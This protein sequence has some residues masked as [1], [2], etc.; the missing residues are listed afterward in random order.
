MKKAKINLLSSRDEYI[1]IERSLQI[2]RAVVIVYCSFFIVAALSFIFLQYQQNKSIQD[3]ID[4]KTSFL[5]YL[6]SYKE[7]E[8]QLV[9]VAKKVKSYNE[10]IRDDARFLPYYS[11]LNSALKSGQESSVGTSSATLS[12]FAID[13]DRI[14]T[15][16]LLFISVEDMVNSFKYVESP[17]FL[18]NFEQLSLK[19]LTVGTQ[20]NENSLSF[21]G[22]FKKIQYETPN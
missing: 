8:A 10:F 3:L 20:Q 4:Q 15:F 9:F 22:K 11:L 14:V 21:S 13:K 17:D 12:S 6:S 2:L 1:R 18:I 5:T 16:T 19:G 7:Q